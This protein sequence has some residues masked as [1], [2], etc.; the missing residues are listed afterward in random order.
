M[1]NYSVV[2]KSVPR[3]DVLEKATGEA[4]YC[5]DIKLPRMLHARVL[6]SPFPH[7]RISSIETTKAARLPG[8][9]YVATGKDAPD[10]RYG[11]I[12]YDDRVL[13]RQTVRAIGAP[14]AAVA[15]ESIDAA[16]EAVGLIDVQYEELPAIFDPEEAMSTNPPVVIHPDLAT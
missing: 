14:V 11:A 6:R 1:A 7:A 2:G 8:V 12:I 15:A 13:P 16:E 10:K 3:V 5:G 4:V 9:V